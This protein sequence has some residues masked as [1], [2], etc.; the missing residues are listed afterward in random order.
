MR[1]FRGGQ[2][3]ALKRG[4][5]TTMQWGLWRYDDGSCLPD[6]DSRST[7][8]RRRRAGEVS[9]T[10]DRREPVPVRGGRYLEPFAFRERLRP[11][12]M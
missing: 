9:R 4:I 7:V 1:S 6:T 5:G 3:Q 10:P 2:R 11:K 8:L 12:A